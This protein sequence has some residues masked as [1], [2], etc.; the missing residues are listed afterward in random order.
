MYTY[1]CIINRVVDGDTVDIDIDLGFGVWLQN[2]R[3]R[4]IGINTPET[5]T[6]DL[7]EKSAGLA[8]S[9]RAK[10]LLPVGSA[11]TLI[12]E[13]FKGKFGRILGDFA[14]GDTTFGNTMLAEGHAVTFMK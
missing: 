4:I 8:A 9:E 3:V 6:R 1:R 5:R 10:Q 13:E 12:S 2:E 14:V 7:E 11:Q